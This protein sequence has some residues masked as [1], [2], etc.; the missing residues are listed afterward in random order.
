M[1][2]L[3]IIQKEEKICRN[4]D[5]FDIDTGYCTYQMGEINPNSKRECFWKFPKEVRREKEV[6]RVWLGTCDNP[7]CKEKTRGKTIFE[8]IPCGLKLRFCN[9]KCKIDFI[10]KLQ[11]GE[12]IIEQLEEADKSE[13][14]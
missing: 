1:T 12:I 7:F 4:C 8:N 13:L 11:K 9:R 10:F 2:E 3:E 6:E 14:E 5:C